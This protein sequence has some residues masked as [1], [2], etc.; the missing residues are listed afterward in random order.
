VTDT[1][2]NCYSQS[3]VLH[4]KAH[5]VYTSRIGV[6]YGVEIELQQATI[7]STRQMANEK[8]LEADQ[9]AKFQTLQKKMEEICQKNKEEV[10]L[11]QKNEK[12][13]QVLKEQY[14]EMKRQVVGPT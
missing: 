6:H 13:M 5:F 1:D 10:T 7:V 2:K 11:S 8:I 12:E 4:I 14:K 9:I 3:Q